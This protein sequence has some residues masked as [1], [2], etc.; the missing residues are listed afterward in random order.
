[1]VF[2]DRGGRSLILFGLCRP[3][4]TG[5]G[6]L[7]AGLTMTRLP[8]FAWAQVSTSILLLVVGVPLAPPNVPGIALIM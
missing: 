7:A 1:V 6:T 4:S 8:P 5:P 2:G 3:R